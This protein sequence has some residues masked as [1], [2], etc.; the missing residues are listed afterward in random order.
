MDLGQLIHN[1]LFG[2]EE[3]KYES[4]KAFYSDSGAFILSTKDEEG[5]VI[6]YNSQE[7][8]SVTTVSPLLS[9]FN[10][11]LGGPIEQERMAPTIEIRDSKKGKATYILYDR[12]E[13]C[14]MVR[15]QRGDRT[16]LLIAKGG[17]QV[18]SNDPSMSDRTMSE[19]A[20]NYKGVFERQQE[21]LDVKSHQ[22][23]ALE[24]TVQ[25]Y[26]A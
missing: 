9:L 12:D 1:L 21:L 7:R 4:V 23:K 16:P 22:K 18:S 20:L 10:K 19:L 26:S 17:S 24:A 5:R 8:Y 25:Q 2:E 15:I 3:P 14:I 6:V 13:E 11:S